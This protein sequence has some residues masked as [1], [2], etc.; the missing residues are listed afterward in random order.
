MVDGVV[1]AVEVV[2]WAV[3]VSAGVSLDVRGWRRSCQRAPAEPAGWGNIPR[4]PR[5]ARRGP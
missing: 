4:K 1:V 2:I 5:P 3:G